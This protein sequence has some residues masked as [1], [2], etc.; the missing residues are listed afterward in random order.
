MWNIYTL[1]IGLKR[2]TRPIGT[3]AV[4]G[5]LTIPTPRPADFRKVL[6]SGLGFFTTFRSA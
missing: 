3:M 1:A 5:I 2:E 6:F 4:T